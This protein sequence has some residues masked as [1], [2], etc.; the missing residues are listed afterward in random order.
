MRR[1]HSAGLDLGTLVI[2]G[3]AS[4]TLSEEEGELGCSKALSEKLN[5]M[6]KDRPGTTQNHQD[7]PSGRNSAASV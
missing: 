2:I 1:Y 6:H 3:V 5:N 7:H 4:F